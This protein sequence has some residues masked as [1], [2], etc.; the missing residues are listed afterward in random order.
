[1]NQL[2]LLSTGARSSDRFVEYK[3][4]DTIEAVPKFAGK[5]VIKSVDEN[6]HGPVYMCVSCV[7]GHDAIILHREVSYHSTHW[8]NATNT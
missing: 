7:D 2:Q 6:I 8:T 1:M 4:G 3:P 5:F